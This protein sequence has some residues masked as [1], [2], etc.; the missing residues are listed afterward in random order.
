MIGYIWTRESNV[1][2]EEKYSIKSQLDA[3]REAAQADG[4][5]VTPDREYEV[6]FSGR[7]LRAIPELKQLRETLERNKGERQR[8]YCYTQDRLIRGEEAEDIFYLLVE[9]RHFNAEV[10]F[11]KNPLDLTTIAGKIMALVA[12]HEAAGEI[13]KI[14]DRTMRGKIQRVK[15]GKLWGLG[16]D[17]FGYRKDR[18]AGLAE[19]EPASAETIRRIFREVCEGKG[20]MAIAKDLNR[21]GIP[22]SFTSRGEK[23]S[24]WHP[25]TV[26]LLL[27]DP[28]YKG[29][30][31]AYRHGGE[32]YRMPDGL[33]PAIVDTGMW[34]RAQERLDLNSGEKARNIS[35]PSLLRGLIFCAVC[36]GRM[37]PVRNH[38]IG[39]Y[40]CSSE[41]LRRHENENHHCG[42]KVTRA[43]WVEREIWSS[44]VWLINNPDQL[45]QSLDLARTV[46]IVEQLQSRLN[47]ARHQIE[48]KGAEQERL[49]RRLRRA[50]GRVAMLIESEIRQLE[51]ERNSLQTEADS[52]SAQLREHQSWR[53]G[54]DEIYENCRKFAA[55]TSGEMT[56][57][58]RRKCLEEWRIAVS[59]NGKWYS[60]GTWGFLSFSKYVI[61][62]TYSVLAKSDENKD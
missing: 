35:R 43:D 38:G 47:V 19:I 24:Q 27:R 1:Y 48:A 60:L 29:E 3:C 42:G 28:A 39:Y 8:I 59:A 44:F 12:G 16:R 41:F 36:N 21:D 55:E 53:I 14:K 49:V 52:I 26:R 34:D 17:K 4:V 62:K 2:D 61:N 31:W 15:E 20:M 6:Q 23:K 11:L 33:F 22:T 56:F 18:E 30:V 13:H 46:G 45:I 25:A 54:V 5:D 40:R 58:R 32:A 10:K 50:E 51:S 37:Y 9:F 57:E 7:D